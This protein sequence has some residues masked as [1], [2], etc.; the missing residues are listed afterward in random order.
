MKKLVTKLILAI[1][2]AVWLAIE[3]GSL[4]SGA[5]SPTLGYIAKWRG[6]A[7]PVGAAVLDGGGKLADAAAGKAPSIVDS[8]TSAVTEAVNRPGAVDR[9]MPFV[10]LAI[11]V[12]LV[13]VVMKVSKVSSKG[14]G[15]GK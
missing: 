11:L 7:R 14:K 2:F 15:K 12:V 1:P 4:R 10:L 5:D 3:V 13:L 9:L 8:G 6:K